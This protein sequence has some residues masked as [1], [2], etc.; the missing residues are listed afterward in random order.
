[1]DQLGDGCAAARFA[2]MCKAKRK[3]RQKG[4]MAHVK[5]N[6]RWNMGIVISSF[7]MLRGEPVRAVKPLY[8]QIEIATK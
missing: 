2:V 8:I 4:W 5:Y 7:K 3:K 6:G 1:M